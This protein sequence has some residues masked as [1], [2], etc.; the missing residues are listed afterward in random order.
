[1]GQVI[2]SE[3]LACGMPADY[4]FQMNTQQQAIDKLK[5]TIRPGDIVLV[6]GA[7]RLKMKQIVDDL[8]VTQTS[9][10]EV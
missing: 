8:A 5:E 1:L 9:L 6:A 4:V 2:G 3:A 7:E 10:C